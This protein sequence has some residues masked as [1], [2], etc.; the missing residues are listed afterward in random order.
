MSIFIVLILLTIGTLVFHFMSPW[1]FTP[2]ASN[3]TLIDTTVDITFVV[4]G[5]IFIAVNLFLAWC[6]YKY[7]HKKVVT[8]DYEPE[9]KKLESW[10]T[11]ITAIGVTAMLAPGLFVWASFVE[12]PKEA[13]QIE[14]VGQQWQWSF[15]FPGKDGKLGTTGVQFINTD[16][17]FG[18][19]TQDPNGND[20]IVV[21][22]NRL[23]LPIN[24][25][26]KVLLRSKDTLHN[27]TVPEFRVKM[28]LVPGMMTFLWF[29]PTKLGEYE[30]LCEELC[31]IGHHAMRGRVIV[32]TE[33]DFQ[34]WLA[35]QQT[36]AQTQ[37]TTKLAGNAARG[38]KL[39]AVCSSCH[40]ADGLGNTTLNSPKL[41]GLDGH[42]LLRQ[43]VHFK[44]SIRG[45]SDEDIY[46]K[47]MIA[48]AATL[49]DENAMRDVISYIQS[50]PNKPSKATVAGDPSRGKKLFETC[51]ACHGLDGR[52]KISQHAPRLSGMND[53]YLVRQIKNYR[54][55]VRGTHPYDMQGAQMRLMSLMDDG[56]INDLVAYINT[57]Q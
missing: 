21:N 43:L 31:G 20:D 44:K 35:S 57:L 56:R 27:F 38:E 41:T 50:L 15:R 54:D 34:G 37:K 42:Y 29:T 36:F 53:D 26:V 7:H 40:G 5:I 2:I 23:H 19:N 9:N 49:P 13:Y 16:N 32:Q 48:M 52:G 33:E 8:A 51:S 55:G 22:H 6:I 1:Y 11:I 25:P 12:T 45:N 4:C 3:W 10:L 47:Q 24:K 39:Y 14:A 30:I 28:D 46:G 18:M 17:P